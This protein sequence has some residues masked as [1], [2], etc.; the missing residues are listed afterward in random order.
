L[1][2]KIG[3]PVWRKVIARMTPLLARSEVAHA[4]Q[5]GLTALE[6]VLEAK[7]AA[8]QEDAGN[9]LPDRPIDLRGSR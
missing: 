3:E 7:P 4:L 8:R 5:E 9:E 1:H 2:G 6:G